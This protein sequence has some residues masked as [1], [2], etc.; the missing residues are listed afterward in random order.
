MICEAASSLFTQ[1]LAYE[2]VSSGGLGI[3][4]LYFMLPLAK[5]ANE[6]L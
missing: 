1:P 4:W 3:S 2:T 6:R 5:I